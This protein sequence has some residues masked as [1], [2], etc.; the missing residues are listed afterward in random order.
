MGSVSQGIQYVQDQRISVTKRSINL[1]KEYKNYLWKVDKDGK[2]IN[3]PESGWD[4]QC[5]AVRY[6]LESLK[7]TATVVPEFPQE[8]WKKRTK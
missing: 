6:A 8:E 7:P 5:D 1:I 2:I 3:T 4:H